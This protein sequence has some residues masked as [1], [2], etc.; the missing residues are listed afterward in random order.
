MDRTEQADT[1]GLT[2]DEGARIVLRVVLREHRFRL[3]RDDHSVQQKRDHFA[4][5]VAVF[6]VPFF[7]DEEA[8][9]PI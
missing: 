9:T 2:R 6:Y 3:A 8:G 1:G 4:A 5:P 7:T